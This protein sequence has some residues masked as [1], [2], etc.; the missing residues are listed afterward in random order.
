MFRGFVVEDNAQD[1]EL[2]AR[3]LSKCVR[4]RF[5]ITCVPAFSAALPLAQRGDHDVVLLNLSLRDSTGLA[6]LHELALAVPRIPIVVL[7]S[8]AR[9]TRCGDRQRRYRLSAY[10]SEVGG[11]SRRISRSQRILWSLATMRNSRT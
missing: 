7:A 9:G 6:S 5:A 8:P 4:P 11:D 3:Q 2:V 1:A 10:W